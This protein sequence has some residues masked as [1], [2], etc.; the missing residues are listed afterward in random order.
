[1]KNSYN[2]LKL[3]GKDIKKTHGFIVLFDI[4]GYGTWIKETSTEEAVIVHKNMEK[5]V[6]TNIAN[7][8]NYAFNKD[9]VRVLSYA[10]TFLI[11][12]NEISDIG[13][14]AIMSACRGMFEAAI[15]FSFPI[16][17]ATACGEFY[18]SQD[19]ITGRPLIEAFEKEKEQEWIG[20]WVTDECLKRIS[21]AEKKEYEANKTI[22][23]YP[24]PL[25]KGEAK[26]FYAYN[27]VDNAIQN[28]RDIN[29]NYLK[30]ESFLQGAKSH[31]LFEKRKMKNTLEFYSFV[32]NRY[33]IPGKKV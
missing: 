21:I 6:I 9:L 5:M 24:I 20:C 19:L 4:L 14:R 1:M 18:A 8:L 17:G 23:L 11:Y 12:T 30:E 33:T 2:F 26:E 28:P 29:L 22:V 32:K 7:F 27:W 10:V 16:R 13:F 15:C 3:D 25:K 31:G